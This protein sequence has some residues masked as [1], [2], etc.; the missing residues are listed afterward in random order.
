LISAAKKLPQGDAGAI[1]FYEVTWQH[2]NTFIRRLTQNP[3]TSREN[4]DSR[5][6]G[7]DMD[8]TAQVFS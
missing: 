3:E 7:N 4:L 8:A 6:R 5:F 2:E 1:I